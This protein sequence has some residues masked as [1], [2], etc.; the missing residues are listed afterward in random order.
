MET[1]EVVL[2]IGNGR[3]FFGRIAWFLYI[4]RGAQG[5]QWHIIDRVCVLRFFKVVRI[6]MHFWDCSNVWV[7]PA[8]SWVVWRSKP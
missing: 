3:K 6:F 1:D 2:G 5:A 4:M 7:F 8:S